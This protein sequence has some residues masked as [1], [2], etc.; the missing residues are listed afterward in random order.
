MDGAADRMQLV[1]GIAPFTTVADAAPA[2]PAGPSAARVL[3]YTISTGGYDLQALTEPTGLA[4]R[5][6]DF[7]RFVDAPTQLALAN[8]STSWRIVPLDTEFQAA[9]HAAAVSMSVLSAEQYLSRTFKIQPHRSSLVWSYAQSIYVDANTRV[10][11]DVGAFAKKVLERVDLATFDFKRTLQSEAQYIREYLTHREPW[12]PRFRSESGLEWL[13]ATLSR[14]MGL[15]QRSGDHLWGRTMPGK[16]VFRRHN[17]RTAAFGDM[18]WREFTGGV[19]R[20]QLSLRWC[21]QESSRQTGLTVTSLGEGGVSGR[22]YN[23]RFTSYFTVMRPKPS[24]TESISCLVWHGP[25]CRRSPASDATAAVKR[26]RGA[27]PPVTATPQRPQNAMK[28]TNCSLPHY[29]LVP[30]VQGQRALAALRAHK[31]HG[32]A[33]VAGTGLSAGRLTASQSALLQANMD[34]WALNQFFFHKDLVP[35]YYNVHYDEK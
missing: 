15:Y 8:V 22:E 17:N 31:A 2:E 1:A 7:V 14:Q 21:A 35:D 16:V 18:W 23:R 32:V 29:A 30:G 19:P 13:N 12:A 20:D 25:V 34:V 11:G 28:A 33:L 3:V 5:S 6:A 10:Y 27:A 26:W 4:A 24:R 9:A